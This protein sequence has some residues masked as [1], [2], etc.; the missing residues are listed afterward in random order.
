[1]RQQELAQAKDPDLAA[2]LQAIQ[3]AAELARKTALQT[4]TAIVVVEQNQQCVR[5]SAQ[6]LRRRLGQ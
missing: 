3:R 4:D 6:D 2:S 5:L 1:M